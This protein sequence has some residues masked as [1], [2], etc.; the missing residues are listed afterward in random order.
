MRTN[1]DDV[2]VHPNAIVRLFYKGVKRL[3]AEKMLKERAYSITREAW[4]GSVFLLG[5]RELTGTTWWLRV[6]KEES[7]AQDLFAHSYEEIDKKR[8]KQNI[9]SIQVSTHQKF[10]HGNVFDGIKRKLENVDLKGCILVCYLM[11]DE[12]IKWSNLNKQ[13]LALSPTP[14]EI[15]IIGN[16]GKLTYGIFKA[17][18]NVCD[19]YI[20]LNNNYQNPEEK[21]FL[22]PYPHRAFRK[23]DLFEPLGKII[24]LKPDFTFEDL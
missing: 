17:Y 20:N 22:H 1:R 16:V 10:D 24:H 19:T 14:S 21:T 4:I 11:R 2:L 8:T 18:P 5:I 7:A 12:L 13:L 15:W 23:G 6:N 9:L 3:G